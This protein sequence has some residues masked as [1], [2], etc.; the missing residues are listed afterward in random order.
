MLT[1]GGGARVQSSFLCFRTRHWTSAL[2]S[3]ILDDLFACV[4]VDVLRRYRR[5]PGTIFDAVFEPREREDA[6]LNQTW[7][8]TTIN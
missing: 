3:S 4:K 6:L 7:R 5:P 2:G 1:T 8:R